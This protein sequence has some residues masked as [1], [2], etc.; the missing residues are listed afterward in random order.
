MKTEMKRKDEKIRALEEQSSYLAEK[1][2]IFETN[3]KNIT[4]QV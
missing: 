4:D 3:L 1:M 2:K